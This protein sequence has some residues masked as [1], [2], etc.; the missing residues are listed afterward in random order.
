MSIRHKGGNM[1]VHPAFKID[2]AEALMH[3]RHRGFGLLVL[4]APEAPIASHVP[5]LVDEQADG[6]LRIELHVARANKLHTY[7]GAGCNALLVCQGPDAYISPDWYGVPNQV[8]TWTYTSVHLTGVAKLLPESEN[9]AHVDRLSAQFEQRLL[10]KR[11]W[12]STK[13]DGARRSA[14]L[15]AIIAMVIEVETIEAQYKLIQHKGEIEHRGAIA[16]LRS[17]DDASSHAI[18][19]L[20]HESMT[21]KFDG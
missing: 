12:S 17:R 8:P 11:P 9:L 19:D 18:A 13:L 5:F 10:P 6:R 2:E 21:K 7:V 15:K 4:P 16:G 14:M 1:Y 20:L 3:L